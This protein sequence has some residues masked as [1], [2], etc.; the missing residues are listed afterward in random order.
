MTS[1]TIIMASV[2]LL[3]NFV[4]A[5][6]DQT[7]QPGASGAAV[8]EAVS[9]RIVTSCIFNDDK[10][11]TR[12]LAFVESHDGNDLDTFR[13]GYY[14]GIWQ[15]DEGMFN[16]TRSAAAIS[17]LQ[18]NLNK[19]RASFGIEWLTVK[20]EDLTKPLYSALA[21]RLYLQYR[22]RNLSIP[23]SIDDQ[24]DYWVRY[25]RL[26]SSRN[27]FIA[28]ANRLEQGCSSSKGAD[29]VFVLDGS[30]SVGLTNFQTM[31]KFVID[32]VNSFDV[33]LGDHQYRIG[34]IK[35]SNGAVRE[36]NLNTY[37]N[38]SDIVN[39]V[40]GINYIGGGTAT[41][42]AIDEMVKSFTAAN[43]AR[44]ANEGHPRVGI[45]VTDGHSNNFQLTNQSAIRAHAAGI[46]MFSVGVGTGVNIQELQI[47]ASPPI[48]LNQFLLEGFTDF[49]GLKDAIAKRT[50]E[51]PIII[52]PGS[53]STTGIRP[54]GDQNCQIRVTASGIT[55]ELAVS[56]GQ[57]TFYISRTTYPSPDFYEMKTEATKDRIGFMYIHQPPTTQL[58]VIVYC[59]IKGDNST[60][61][62][63]SI[64]TK[65][66]E[67]DGCKSQ[68]C[69]NSGACVNTPGGGYR[70]HC[71]SNFTGQ[72]CETEMPP[73]TTTRTAFITREPDTT[74]A[75]IEIS[76]TTTTTQATTI[77]TT[78]I[79]TPAFMTTLVPSSP[80][81]NGT[82]NC[83][84]RI[85]CTP[86]NIS[87]GNLYFPH[88]DPNKFV[89][90]SNSYQCYVFSCPP[91]LEWNAAAGACD[92]P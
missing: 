4:H 14:G 75:S 88:D 53:N 87:S 6:H 64:S 63:V 38:K 90:C 13:P 51:A 59:N 62:N 9:D 78:P 26:Q 11:F 83:H 21:A 85:P 55:I 15:V 41:H 5:Q 32:V 37:H 40:N 49:D 25:Y 84:D 73:S 1:L 44:P 74:S 28:E 80:P 18:T 29:M 27:E 35:Y 12:R 69:Q 54:G 60:E 30:G 19:I 33:G 7:I 77:T 3:V 20:W 22:S 86:E 31:K 47:I 82:Y 56:G 70:C 45:V 2:S 23:R 46:I 57:T 42:L 68:S 61:S 10:L 92:W 17:Y 50:C 34:V 16:E 79:P 65:P 91:R 24:A 76:A 72:N 89:Q 52:S 67:H 81:R 58:E 48:C 8:V 39:A 36:F 71:H 43:G 66:G